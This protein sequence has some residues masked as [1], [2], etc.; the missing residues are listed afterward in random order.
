M[1]L[2]RFGTAGN[3]KPGLWIHGQYFDVSSVIEDYN[4]AFFAG[5]GMKKLAALLATTTFPQISD[6]TRLGSPVARPSKL[7]GVGLNYRD[8]AHESGLALPEE[9]ILFMKATSALC[10]GSDDLLLP[11]GSKKTDWEIEL[12]FVIGKKATYVSEEEAMDHVAGYLCLNDYSERDYQLERCGQWTK[13]K[14]CDTF[15]PAG[16]FLVSKD[17]IK[18]VHQLTMR[19]SVNGKLYQ[20]STTSQL[21]FRIPFL[22]S[23]ISQFMTLLPGDI[24]TTGTPAGVGMGQRPDPV[25]LKAGDLVEWEIEGLGSN[26]QRV[27]MHPEDRNE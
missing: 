12:A 3:E 4:D 18:D 22:V 17:E 11:K 14:S 27:C 5:N 19:L 7:I 26:R 25:F 1:K 20:E 16:P 21:I 8:H 15:A 23:Y 24:V 9:P 13:G 10:G 6:Q 2:I